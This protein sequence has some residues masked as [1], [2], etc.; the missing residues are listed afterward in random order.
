M[1]E[2]NSEKIVRNKITVI[3]FA[4]SIIVIYIHT[5]NLE[6]YD[7]NL[8]DGGLSALIYFVEE[9]FKT[10]NDVAVPSFFFIS[11]FLF[12]RT[13]E[14]SLLKNKYI[15][16]IK[17]VVIPYLVWC[18]IYYLYFVILTN[19]P[20][21]K[22]YVNSET[23][24]LSVTNWILSLW[25][26]E[27]CVLWFLKYLIVFIFIAP[28]IYAFLKNH[29]GVPVGFLCLVFII[30]STLLKII[31]IP[32]G[33]DMYAAGSY[34][35]INHRGLEYYKNRKVSFAALTVALIM[36]CS[37]TVTLNC[38]TMI[39]FIFCVWISL[40]I[41]NLDIDMP[42]WLSI[43]FFSYVFHDMILEMLEK[44]FLIMFGKKTICAIVDYIFMPWIC[45]CI[46]VIV[47]FVLRKNKKIWGV[48]SGFR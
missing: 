33:L 21:V 44:V 39:T 16:R 47:A 23:I 24:K 11:G 45:F 19:V 38:V 3:S 29:F 14:L 17:S 30:I 12:F 4:C 20:I 1:V 27:Y 15:T 36:F 32:L 8:N 40:D 41:I 34:I 7:I 9:W 5:Y 28:V 10:F 46:I 6:V 48:L 26:N 42:W 31:N 22:N 18:S 25:E 43:S 13:F 37:Q 35:A 2:K